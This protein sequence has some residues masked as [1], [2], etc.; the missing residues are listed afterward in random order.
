MKLWPSWVKFEYPND[1]TV[2]EHILPDDSLGYQFECDLDWTNTY[3]LSKD[4]KRIKKHKTEF[5]LDTLYY[6]ELGWEK[7]QIKNILEALTMEHNKNLKG[8]IGNLIFSYRK[9]NSVF[10]CNYEVKNKEDFNKVFGPCNNY[11]DECAEL[12]KSLLKGN[13]KE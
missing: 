6:M 5:H 3:Y 10:P 9:L 8:V 7:E 11:P 2:I 1:S 13:L 12:E 4:L